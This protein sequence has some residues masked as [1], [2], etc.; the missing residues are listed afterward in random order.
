MSLFQKSVAGFTGGQAKTYTFSSDWLDTRPYKIQGYTVAMF[1]SQFECIYSKAKPE[2][3]TGTWLYVGFNE[4]PFFRGNNALSEEMF[5]LPNGQQMFYSQYKLEG[6]YKNLNRLIPIHHTDATAV[7]LSKKE[8]LPLRSVTQAEVLAGY[9]KFFASNR[10]DT[11]RRQESVLAK[12]PGNKR[13]RE[14]LDETKKEI[15][16]CNTTIDTYIKR[17]AANSP[18]FVEGI[19][20]YCNPEKMFLNPSNSKARAVVVFDDAYFDKSL[21]PGVPQFIVVYWRNEDAY[22]KTQT[23]DFRFPLKREFM[24]KFEA[25]FDFAA[26]QKMLS[27]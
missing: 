7:F 3:A 27:P 19:D 21:A 18:A 14:I 12:E 5:R 1:F 17:S 13:S 8:R 15:E 16:T 23:G 11:I 22:H 26:L 2:A 25:N 6:K 4:I 10:G 20:Y 24:G 9:K